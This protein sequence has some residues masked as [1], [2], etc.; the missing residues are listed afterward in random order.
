M[1]PSRETFTKI[2]KAIPEVG[3]PMDTLYL[4]LADPKLNYCCFCVAAEALRELGLVRISPAGS[5]ISR[6]KVSQKAQLESAPILVSLREILD[7]LKS[8]VRGGEK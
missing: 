5:V 1:Y 3:I 4:R 2:Y 7:G 6:I 8:K